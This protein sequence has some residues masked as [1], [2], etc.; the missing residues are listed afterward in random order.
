MG[1]LYRGDI[2]IEPNWNNG[3]ALLED[4]DFDFADEAEVFWGYQ[5]S[6]G[7]IFYIILHFYL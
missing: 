7:M 2:L 3:V 6:D 1:Q 5:P 4:Y